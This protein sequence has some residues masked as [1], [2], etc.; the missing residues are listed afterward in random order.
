MLSTLKRLFS[1]SSNKLYFKKSYAQSGEDLIVDFIFHEI[2]IN[3]PSYL[4]I[5]AHHPYYLN[6]TA[7]FYER[8]CYGINIEPTPNLFNEF[9]AKRKRDINLNIGIGE[10]E[11]MLEFYE[12]SVPTLNT[13]SKVEAKNYAKEGMF[14]IQKVTPVKVDTVRNIL[15]TYNNGI[16]PD[17]LSLDVEGLDEMIV[18]SIDYEGNYP[19][20]IC[21]ETISFSTSGR[22]VK[23][24][25]LISYIENQGY[26]LYADTNINSIFVRKDLWIR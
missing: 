2:G 14:S 16:F 15:Q 4:D 5:G 22:G 26:L 23:N 11:G 6:N 17:F 9:L 13:F 19:K 1:R 18:Q 7:I 25:K 8:G 3:D 20:V 12:M 10:K 24:D 21:I